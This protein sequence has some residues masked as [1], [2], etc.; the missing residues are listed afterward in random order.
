MNVCMYVCIHVRI[1][2]YVY[3]YIYIY[4]YARICVYREG[5]SDFKNSAQQAEAAAACQLR[6]HRRTLRTAEN[7]R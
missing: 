7:P 1:S 2:I 4:V 6:L 5:P 3:V